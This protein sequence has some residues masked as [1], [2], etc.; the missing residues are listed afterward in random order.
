[1]SSVQ[2]TVNRNSIPVISA[3]LH[4][5]CSQA[6]LALAP[7]PS[8]LLDVGGNGRMSCFVPCQVTNANI[9]RGIDGT[10][11]PYNDCSFDVCTSVAVLEHVSDWKA[12][13]RESVRVGAR[14]AVHWFPLGSVAREI[15]A[16]KDAAG[17]VH[18][19]EI[20]EVDEV[21]NYAATIC[22]R[23][24]L[25]PFMNVS[26]HLLL[27]ATVNRRM[28]VD[29]T[30]ELVRDRGSQNYGYLLSLIP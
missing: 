28:D 6:A 4:W 29:A 12:F 25:T 27:L 1:M 11:L 5:G 2:D 10:N 26:E 14:G 8:T 17:H 16:Y 21:A 22:S 18:P 7:S 13:L 3:Y 30:Y 19:C 20:Y 24:I 9:L 23:Y 15:E